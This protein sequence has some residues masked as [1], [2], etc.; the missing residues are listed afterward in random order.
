MLLGFLHEKNCGLE[1][2]SK[3]VLASMPKME[4]EFTFARR[5]DIA[6]LSCFAL[7]ISVVIKCSDQRQPRGERVHF[8]FKIP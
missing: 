2:L 3:E 7:F 1:W 8:G 6:C 5:S 4:R